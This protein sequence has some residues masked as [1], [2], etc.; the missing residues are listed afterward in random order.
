[1]VTRLVNAVGVELGA[2]QDLMDSHPIDNPTGYWE[3]QAVVDLNDRLLES[4]GGSWDEPPVLGDGW[5]ESWD[6]QPMRDQARKILADLAGCGDAIGWKDPRMSLLLPFWNT[7]LPI[8]AT[9]MVHRH[10][11]QVAASLARRDGIDVEHGAHLWSRYT[12]A[13]WRAHTN[14]AVIAYEYALAQPAAAAVNLAAFLDRPAPDQETLAEVESFVDPSLS[15]HADAQPELGR[16]MTLAV[17][18]QALLETQEFTLIDRL[19]D[20]LHEEWLD[21]PS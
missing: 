6:L 14:R 5:E 10:P 2:H 12:V 20:A 18:V 1:M 7:V 15:R 21:S 3:H 4:F 8:T 9:V 16:H 13:A 11:F 19:F 17:A